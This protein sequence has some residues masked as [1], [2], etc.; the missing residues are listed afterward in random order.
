MT[1]PTELPPHVQ[2]LVDEIE[3]EIGESDV[4]ADEIEGDTGRPE[5]V[6][7][8]AV[9]E[10]VREILLEIGEDP[11]RQGLLGTPERVHRMYTELTAGYHVDP[12][13]L[14]N[15]AVFDAER[16]RRRPVVDAAPHPC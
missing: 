5:V 15:N 6:H 14:I 12:D 9:E 11:G 3:S 4:A 1:S 16:T 2:Q 8:G 7:D 13:R 10:A